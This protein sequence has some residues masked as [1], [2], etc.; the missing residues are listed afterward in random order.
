MQYVG[1][2]VTQAEDGMWHA[3][4]QT[5]EALVSYAHE[6]LTAVKMWCVKQ[7]GTGASAMRWAAPHGVR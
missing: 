3:E 5:D 7:S 6:T 2:T 4:G 1:F